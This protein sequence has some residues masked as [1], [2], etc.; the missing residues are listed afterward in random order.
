MRLKVIL[1]LLLLFSSILKLQS[2]SYQAI[3]SEIKNFFLDIENLVD[4]FLPQKSALCRTGFSCYEEFSTVVLCGPYRKNFL[5]YKNEIL[6]KHFN[7]FLNSAEAELKNPRDQGLFRELIFSYRDLIFNWFC[8]SVERYKNIMKE[9][10]FVSLDRYS[11]VNDAC[12]S[13]LLKSKKIGSIAG[14]YNDISLVSCIGNYYAD[15][16]SRIKILS[17]RHDNVIFK[18]TALL[19]KDKSHH[20]LLSP[21][22]NRVLQMPEVLLEA[23]SEFF[24]KNLIS[25]TLSFFY[26]D[27]AQ[28]AEELI[29]ALNPGFRTNHDDEFLYAYESCEWRFYESFCDRCNGLKMVDYNLQVVRPTERSINLNARCYDYLAIVEAYAENFISTLKKKIHDVDDELLSVD[30]SSIK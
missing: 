21:R 13:Q 10:G 22:I 19:R 16:F 1:L 4:F 30:E 20:I 26:L 28:A 18:L 25:E 15:I 23:K 7:S 2:I 17:V 9:A 24:V 29:I 12:R 14:L 6:N 5:S 27:L 8:L 11:K 3:Y